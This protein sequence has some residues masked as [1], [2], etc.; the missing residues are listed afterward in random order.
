MGEVGGMAKR[1][2]PPGFSA[3]CALGR[4]Q[5]LQPERLRREQK[6]PSHV[7]EIKTQGAQNILAGRYENQI[8]T[9]SSAASTARAASAAIPGGSGLRVGEWGLPKSPQHL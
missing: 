8:S 4:R 9:Q 6:S 2:K 1:G 5:A 7:F 3:L